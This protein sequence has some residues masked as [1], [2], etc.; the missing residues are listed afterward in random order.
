MKYIEIVCIKTAYKYNKKSYDIVVCDEVHT[1]LSELYMLFFI[2]NSYKHIVGLT[3]T[4]EDEEKKSLLSDFMPV[5]HTTPV[6]V[7][8]E[9]GLISPF[10]IYNLSVR[11]TNEETTKIASINYLYGK[12]ESTLGGKYMCFNN[13]NIYK[14]KSYKDSHPDKHNAANMLWIHMSRRKKILTDASN[15]IITTKRI[16][17]KFPNKKILVFCKSVQMAEK[18]NDILGDI[19]T[20]FHSNTT[21]LKKDQK[22]KNLKD[23]SED[24]Y[25]ILVSVDALSA[26]LNIPKC[27][28]GICVAGNSKT[29]EDTQRRGRIVRRDKENPDKVGIY[30]NLYI[31]NTQEEKW[32]KSRLKDVDEKYVNYIDFLEEI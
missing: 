30:F 21:K 32:V 13:A 9:L 7:A 31:P 11:L 18:I 8:I 28:L 12:C 10:L 1:Q 2:Q 5:V 4:I 25:R 26:G 3:A 6:N 24:K 19:S 27:D 22:L 20:I 17:D 14:K 15:K 23:F 16:V 29:L